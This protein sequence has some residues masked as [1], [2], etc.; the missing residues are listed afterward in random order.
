MFLAFLIILGISFYVL[1][2]W[3]I[4]DILPRYLESMEET[5]VDTAVVLAAS[6]EPDPHTGQPEITDL[7]RTFD[8]A[9]KN[10]INAVINGAVGNSGMMSGLSRGTG[11]TWAIRSGAMGGS[12]LIFPLS[13]RRPFFAAR[14]KV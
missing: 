14:N 10:S 2:S 1:I 5:M 9:L 3:I 11:L 8:R 4:N 7:R 12:A 6:I 13:C